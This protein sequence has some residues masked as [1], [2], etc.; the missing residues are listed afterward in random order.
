[1]AV[2]SGRRILRSPAETF[3]ALYRESYPLVYNYVRF[4]MNNEDATEDV[5]S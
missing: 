1:M 3:E 2:R 5:V 4:R